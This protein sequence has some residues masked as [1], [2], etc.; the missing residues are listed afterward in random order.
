MIVTHYSDSFYEGPVD[1]IVGRLAREL[2]AVDP[3][4]TGEWQSMDV[5]DS[6]AHMTHELEDV[7][8]FCNVPTAPAD[9]TRD[10]KPDMPWA[11]R[12]FQE[13]VLGEPLNPPPSH[14]DWPYAVRGNADH[15]DEN[16]KFDH[17]YPE[18]FWPKY[19]E[20]G[21]PAMDG[22]N[23]GIRFTYGD[24]ADVV[25]LLALNPG[26]RQAY[27]PVWFPEDTGGHQR[28][29]ARVPCTLGYHFMIR[30]GILSMRYYLRSCDLRRHFRNDIYMAG[31]LQQ[32][33]V[34]Q[35]PG[36][37]GPTV[38][39]GHMRMHIASMHSFAAD[40]SHVRGMMGG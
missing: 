39:P 3:I 5:T 37:G 8:V 23:M 27:L 1:A 36:R 16:T 40:D 24:L 25:N 18:R 13:R 7:N 2:M 9:W 32:W 34:S 6:A 31:R 17:T 21:V 12:H 15:T 4:H 26:T 29:N 14:V 28:I 38:I 22:P 19:A 33:V 10:C 30:Y 35:L 20:V 11:E